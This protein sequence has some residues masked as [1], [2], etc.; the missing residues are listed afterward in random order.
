MRQV[1]AL[2][3]LI[4]ISALTSCSFGYTVTAAFIGDR[5]T[6]LADFPKT[7]CGINF[8]VR[9]EDKKPLWAFTTLDNA[10]DQCPPRFPLEYGH[11]PANSQVD[12]PAVPLRLGQVYVIEGG[13]GAGELN[14]AFVL[15]AGGGKISVRNLPPNSEAASAVLDAPYKAVMD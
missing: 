9:A 1:R 12:T 5:L 6:F 3:C 13:G 4:L 15:Y 10:S 8:Q 2:A 14:G 7:K 11:A